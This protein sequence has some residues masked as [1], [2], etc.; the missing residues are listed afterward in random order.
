MR[1]IVLTLVAAVT[2]VLMA[3]TVGAACPSGQLAINPH[4]SY[5]PLP[6]M[7]SSPAT[8][9]IVS[10]NST[11]G[12]FPHI[13]LVMTQASYDGLS[14]PV[15]VTWTGK[16]GESNQSIFPKQSFQPTTAGYIPDQAVTPFD[17]G[18]YKVETLKI[19][20]GVNGTKADTLWYNFG[21]FL[22]GNPI[23]QTPRNF[24]VTLPST[25]P[26]MLVLAVARSGVCSVFFNMRVAPCAPGFIVPEI[27]PALLATASFA[28]IGIYALRRRKP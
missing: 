11:Y 17:T 5:Y 16:S 21:P 19:C 24:T 14:G 2:L 6:I 12:I 26:R 18:R 1:R 23:T 4:G 13:V 15:V 7:L 9:T 3:R 22:A 25:Q 20:L 8:F 27:P 28:V 10:V